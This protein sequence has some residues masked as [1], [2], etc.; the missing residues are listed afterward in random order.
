MHSKYRCTWKSLQFFLIKTMMA[1]MMRILKACI[2][3]KYSQCIS[4]IKRILYTTTIYIS[5]C[6]FVY[7]CFF[8]FTAIHA[9]RL[10]LCVWDWRPYTIHYH[11]HNLPPN[12]PTLPISWKGR[13]TVKW[14][15]W[16]NVIFV[17][18]SMSNNMQITLEFN[19]L[20][21]PSKSS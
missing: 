21:L 3:S 18:Y 20:K 9:E 1:S 11:F 7:I 13:N 2:S 19:M 6:S 5:S 10:A 4:A 15:S 16:R 17:Q 8:L 12:L 14:T